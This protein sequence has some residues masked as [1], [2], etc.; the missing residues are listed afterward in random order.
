MQKTKGLLAIEKIVSE[1]TISNQEE[2]LRKLK[3]KGIS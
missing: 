3:G 1:E 2:L